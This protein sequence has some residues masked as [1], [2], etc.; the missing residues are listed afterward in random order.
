[1]EVESEN[2]LKKGEYEAILNKSG[3]QPHVVAF[4]KLGIG[5]LQDV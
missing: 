3:E 2:K 1:M 4:A 5:K